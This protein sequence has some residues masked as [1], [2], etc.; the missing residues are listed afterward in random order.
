MLLVGQNGFG[1]LASST[2]LL[3]LLGVGDEV[4]GVGVAIPHS[5][6]ADDIVCVLFFVLET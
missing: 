2:K 4:L 5:N 1:Y 6:S 3:A